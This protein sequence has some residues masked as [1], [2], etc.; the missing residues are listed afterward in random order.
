MIIN[1]RGYTFQE[2]TDYVNDSLSRFG[3]VPRVDAPELWRDWAV[4]VCALGGISYQ[5]PPNPYSYDDWVEW[6]DAFNQ[7]VKFDG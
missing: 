4:A 2:W 7:A 3:P 1:P 5:H 6:A